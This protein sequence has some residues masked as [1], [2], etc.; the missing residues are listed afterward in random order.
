MR[1][2]SEC[3]AL[4]K[5][6]LPKFLQL[7]KDTAEGEASSSSAFESKEENRML[8]E[9]ATAAI[10]S[11]SQQRSSDFNL[12]LHS[13]ACNVTDHTSLSTSRPS[14]SSF[15]TPHDANA[16][17]SYSA[18]SSFIEHV[19]C[20]ERD[21][22]ETA[23]GLN[24][25]NSDFV[26]NAK[27]ETPRYNF[28]PKKP[29][30][31]KPVGK[32]VSCSALQRIRS[33]SPRNQR[34]ETSY[35]YGGCDDARYQNSSS[36]HSQ[37]SRLEKTS[38]RNEFT[39]LEASQQSPNLK[40]AIKYTAISAEGRQMSMYR[41]DVEKLTSS[42]LNSQQFQSEYNYNISS[43][44]SNFT[45]SNPNILQTVHPNNVLQT[46]QSVPSSQSSGTGKTPSNMVAPSDEEL[47]CR[48]N[49]AGLAEDFENASF[50]SD[51]T[52]TTS[53]INALS[54]PIT[55]GNWSTDCKMM[56]INFFI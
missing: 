48:D 30:S 38:S 32:E 29:S 2:F 43:L 33:G 13:N 23:R 50:A 44:Y 22:P 9:N 27:T 3:G 1:F 54:N 12:Q 40:K 14:L 37:S 17:T 21:E 6:D 10:I 7:V 39:N 41:D 25:Q 20:D 47:P 49:V 36:M 28:S 51:E 34:E 24:L 15:S 56:V 45:S 31:Q 53:T 18:H 46:L 11:G 8:I 4:K 52:Y 26:K 55:A 42:E 19:L 16:E 35:S 5:E